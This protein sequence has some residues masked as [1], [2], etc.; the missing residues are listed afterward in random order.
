MTVEL[1]GREVAAKLTKKFPD[2]VIESGEVAILV[3]SDSLLAIAEYLKNDPEFDFDYLNHLTGVDYIDY[4]EVVY[5][6]TSLK[7]NHNLVIKTRCP[8]RENPTLPSVIN[9]WRGADYQEREIYDLLG[10]NFEGHPN[11]KRIVLW[12]GFEGHP[13][14]KDYL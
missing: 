7:H 9:I 6:F 12:P 10:I 2:G 8:D 11:L 1:S 14:R 4:F 13:L 5:Q 3:N